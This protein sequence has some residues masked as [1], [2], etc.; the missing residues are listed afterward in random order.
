MSARKP[1]IPKGLLSR[2]GNPRQGWLTIVPADL[3]QR[4]S[5]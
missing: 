1:D 5:R 4:Q 2:G 3:V